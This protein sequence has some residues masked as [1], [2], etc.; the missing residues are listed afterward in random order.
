MTGAAC[1]QH[2]LVADVTDRIGE[3]PPVGRIACDRVI[4]G[5]WSHADPYMT[6]VRNP[7]GSM[8]EPADGLAQRRCIGVAEVNADPCMAGYDVPRAG[9]RGDLAGGSE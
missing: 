7:V 6:L 2:W 9:R 3:N 1:H 5:K 8:M 4:Q